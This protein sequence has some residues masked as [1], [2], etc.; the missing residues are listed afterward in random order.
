MIRRGSYKWEIKRF[1]GGQDSYHAKEEIPDGHHAVVR[2]FWTDG[3]ALNLRYGCTS[4]S[5]G[6]HVG[7]TNTAGAKGLYVWYPDSGGRHIAAA[8]PKADSADKVDVSFVHT[9]GATALGC[10]LATSGRIGF[11][12]FGQKLYFCDGRNR[13]MHTDGSATA[14]TAEIDP[15]LAAGH[16]S[17][18]IPRA[19]RRNLRSLGR[20]SWGNWP[21]KFPCWLRVNDT[22]AYAASGT[23][24][25]V[26]SEQSG[27]HPPDHRYCLLLQGTASIETGAAAYFNHGTGGTT[28][29][30][31]MQFWGHSNREGQFLSM[32]FGHAGKQ[33]TA[34]MDIPIRF[35]QSGRWE[36]KDI[37]LT[38]LP[39]SQRQNLGT[40]RITVTDDVSTFTV[41]F[42]LNFLDGAQRGIY[43]YAPAFYRSTDNVESP[44]NAPVTVQTYDGEPGAHAVY[45]PPR[46]TVDPTVD[47]VRWYRRGESSPEWRFVAD[48]PVG[49]GGWDYL[50]DHETGD[51]SSD[52][53]LPA[54]H[55]NIVSKFGENRMA[56]WGG[57]DYG[58]YAAPIYTASQLLAT[59]AWTAMSVTQNEGVSV[60]VEIYA[61][62]AG[63]TAA[64]GSVTLKLQKDVSGSMT[65]QR[66]ATISPSKL[67]MRRRNTILWTGS[68]N[69]GDSQVTLGT[70]QWQLV[71]SALSACTW[72]LG[73]WKSAKPSFYHLLD[74]PD[75]LFVSRQDEPTYFDRLTTMDTV[76][77]DGFWLE[78]PNA[79]NERITGQ[80]GHGSHHVAST[81]SGSTLVVGNSGADISAMRLHSSIGGASA[82]T[83]AECDD[84]VAWVSGTKGNLRVYAFGPKIDSGIWVPAHEKGGFNR[85]GLPIE[86]ILALVTDPSDMSATFAKGKYHLFFGES[87]TYKND[88]YTGASYDFATHS[89]GT[90]YVTHNTGTA[91]R[92]PRF[93]TTILDTGDVLLG[94]PNGGTAA[95]QNKLWLFDYKDFWRD[96][97]ASIPY[98][99][100]TRHRALQ[101]ASRTRLRGYTLRVEQPTSGWG[102]MSVNVNAYADLSTAGTVTHTMTSGA[103]R[104]RE[105]EA[106]FGA[107]AQGA[108]VGSRLSGNNNIGGSTHVGFTVRSVDLYL[109]RKR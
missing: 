65:T 63:A 4:V 18:G 98:T 37:D 59:S 109:D 82:E 86:P 97:Q 34:I 9:S 49:T 30:S 76:D 62:T 95:S 42:S 50:A 48:V 13:F 28:T 79:N 45:L 80:G 103:G 69:A 33:A 101:N 68:A 57:Y 53:P 46:T 10:S 12:G 6:T 40:S 90:H 104:V 36:F 17:V 106:R 51:L 16:T 89:W 31:R 81:R 15:P 44:M 70:A 38:H 3:E 21:V 105:F 92:P 29:I 88:T 27:L 54:P 39:L 35:D 25:Y 64:S 91:P 87:V 72:N 32:S 67:V 7:A 75:R 23:G 20:W 100:E 102:G 74:F 73:C 14:P 55:G 77:T 58:D 56:V 96:G 22:K 71:F 93:A 41:R 108:Y 19:Q 78:L 94:S 52:V 83:Y 11:A 1:T 43:E 61:W 85:I 99:F 107:G 24:L 26:N 47:Y 2:N 8:Y 60:G 84:W 66:T 5:G